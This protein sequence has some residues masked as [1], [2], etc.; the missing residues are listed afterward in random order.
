MTDAELYDIVRRAF[1]LARIQA[2]AREMSSCEV[3]AYANAI[4]K[5]LQKKD[6]RPVS[7]A[8]GVGID[9]E[10]SIGRTHV[11]CLECGKKFKILT[12]HHLVLHDLNAQ[13]YKEKW[14]L[15]QHEPLICGELASNRRKKMQTQRLWECKKTSRPVDATLAEG[16]TVE[17]VEK[18]T[19]QVVPIV[20]PIETNEKEQPATK[21][22]ERPLLEKTTQEK[23]GWRQMVRNCLQGLWKNG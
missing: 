3:L 20:L 17:Y 22:S 1:E 15:D 7:V 5:A 18:D 10:E 12:R 13:T 8:L 21:Y 19:N 2:G 14:G 6:E 11:I 4:V 16:K 23:P 9:P